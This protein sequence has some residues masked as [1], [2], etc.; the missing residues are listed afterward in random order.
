MLRIGGDSTDRTWYP[1][2]GSY[3]SGRTHYR[4]TPKWV[5]IV[6][7]MTDGA[8]AHLVLGINLRAHSARLA[9]AEAR[10]LLNGLAR[11]RITAF[12]IGHRARALW[13]FGDGFR[14]VAS[15]VAQLWL[16][17]ASRPARRS[18]HG[19]SA[20]ALTPASGARGGTVSR[21]GHGARVCR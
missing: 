21:A 15:R 5:E 16:D 1:V 7:A 6:R 8:R 10:F 13:A 3:P 2:G 4:L 14:I 12:E 11:R 9:D 19:Q 18:G 20:V 17:S